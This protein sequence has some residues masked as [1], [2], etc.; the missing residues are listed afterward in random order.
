MSVANCIH[1]EIEKMMI[2]EDVPFNE[3][4]E[5]FMMAI[6]KVLATLLIKS[7]Y[8]SLLKQTLDAPILTE[9]GH[10]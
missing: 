7:S 1:V 8:N 4:E 2:K 5:D 10:T 3:A 6:R 9:F